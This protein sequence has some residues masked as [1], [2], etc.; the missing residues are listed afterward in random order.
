MDG[1]TQRRR[2]PV[3]HQHSQ[4]V[5]QHGRPS[6]PSGWTKTT[7]QCDADTECEFTLDV[8]LPNGAYN[9]FLQV[10]ETIGSVTYVKRTPGF[11]AF[12]ILFPDRPVPQTPMTRP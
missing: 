4:G 6:I 1:H 9:W 2:C 11:A 8:A 5:G 3:S 12:K 7:A 10:R